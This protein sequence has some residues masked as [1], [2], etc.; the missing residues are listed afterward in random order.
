M[1][2]PPFKPFAPP[3]R[4]SRPTVWEP[5]LYA[6]MKGHRR[7][8]ENDVHMNLVVC[9]IRPVSSSNKI[10]KEFGCL[11]ILSVLSCV[12]NPFNCRDLVFW[13]YF[14]FFFAL[15]QT[16]CKYISPCIMKDPFPSA[17]YLDSVVSL[18]FVFVKYILNFRLKCF[19]LRLIRLYKTYITEISLF[20][21]LVI[22]NIINENVE[23]L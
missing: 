20:N 5:L 14:F 3:P 22:N 11:L 4:G 8:W 21:D 6:Q 10:R 16:S 13:S 9:A 19:D 7:N 18:D 23:I 2:R 1:L 17:I 12:I 15:Q